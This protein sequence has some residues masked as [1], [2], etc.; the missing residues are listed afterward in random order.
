MEYLTFSSPSP[1][2]DGDEFRGSV[3]VLAP[4]EGCGS[5]A[6]ANVFPTIRFASR[7]APHLVVSPAWRRAGRSASWPA[8]ARREPAVLK[9]RPYPP[10]FRASGRT[11]LRVSLNG[12]ELP[13]LAAGLSARATLRLC[14]SSPLTSSW[15]FMLPHAVARADS[16]A[17]AIAP[18]GRE[19]KAP[20]SSAVTREAR[21]LVSPSPYCATAS[22]AFAQ[23]AQRSP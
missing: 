15:P 14:S 8:M 18:S 10:A 13:T 17:S 9:A 12:H 4:A 5:S 23:T 22:L 21:L 19:S 2:A 11:L 6:E 3:T 20:M 1:L 16:G 7:P